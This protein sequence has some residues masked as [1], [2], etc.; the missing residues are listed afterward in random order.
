MNDWK[1][2]EDE[3]P[4]KNKFVLVV[5]NEDDY[6]VDYFEPKCGW[7][8]STNVVAWHEIEPYLYKEKTKKQEC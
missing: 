4:P 5:D 3:L 8:R 1:N 2:V 7:D 6:T